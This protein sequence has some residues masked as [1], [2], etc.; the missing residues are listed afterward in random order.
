M[1]S[2]DGNVFAND[3]CVSTLT[4]DPSE[5]LEDAGNPLLSGSTALSPVGKVVG[6]TGGEDEG[7]IRLGVPG[8]VAL[9]RAFSPADDPLTRSLIMS[10]LRLDG[11]TRRESTGELLPRPR[12]SS[13]S[14]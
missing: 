4:N 2:W 6:D 7:F 12:P 3:P 10:G 14:G 8:G 1:I 9:T 11:V 13:S 5:P